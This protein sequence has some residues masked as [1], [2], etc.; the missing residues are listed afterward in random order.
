MIYKINQEIKERALEVISCLGLNHISEERFV[1]IL[2]KGS[3]SRAIA[4]CHGL[5]KVMQMALNVNA[6][7]VLEFIEERFQK[8]S[9]AEKTKVIIHELLHI[10][11]NLGGGFRHHDFVNNKKVEVLYKN[12]IAN[13][14][15]NEKNNLF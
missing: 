8:L 6:V 15:E 3:K 11:K 14:L 5:S 9:E 4:R 12:Y 2:S 10:P 1:C 13:K 7:Y